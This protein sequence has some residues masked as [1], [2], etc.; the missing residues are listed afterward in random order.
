M[1]IN[2]HAWMFP[3]GCV[4]SAVG[5]LAWFAAAMAAMG[6]YAPPAGFEMPPAAAS[7]LE[8]GPNGYLYLLLAMC[9]RVQVYA[10]GGEMVA[11]WQVPSSGGLVKME[12]TEDGNIGIMVERGDLYHE[13]SPD[14]QA[15]G[16]RDLTDADREAGVLL[17]TVP[18]GPL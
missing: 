6:M 11:G 12:I 4:L 15:L 13:F 10:P 3:V 9:S 17:S 16:Q 1:K 14:G 5:L 8:V 7:D 2:F 18:G